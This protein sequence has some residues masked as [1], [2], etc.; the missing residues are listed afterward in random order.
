MIDYLLPE[1]SGIQKGT[2]TSWVVQYTPA[3]VIYYTLFDRILR[4]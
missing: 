4:S 1:N 3:A 2:L